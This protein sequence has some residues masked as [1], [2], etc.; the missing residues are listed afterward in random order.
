MLTRS[1]D[2]D[3]AALTTLGKRH[4]IRFHDLITKEAE[5]NKALA[6]LLSMS[7]DMDKSSSI[8]SS[9][10]SA[11]KHNE[12]NT[13]SSS[14]NMLNRLLETLDLDNEDTKNRKQKNNDSPIRPINIFR[15]MLSDNVCANCHQS[16]A[17]NEQIVNAAGHIW[18]TH[19]FVCTQCFQPFENGIY[20]E[21]E[22]RKYC[23][24]DFQM[25]F[26]PCC[27]ECKQA[28]V[29]RVIRAIQ[30]CFHPDCFRCQLCQI[31]LIEM[32]FS[33][34]N[35]RAL[36]RECHIKEK[37]KD[38]SLSQHI[39][40]KCHQIIDNHCLK[41][42]DEYHHAYHFQCTSCQIQL[43]E[44][45][46]EVRGLLYCLPCYNKL[47]VPVCGACRRLIDDRV[48]SA[49]GK[50]WHVEHFCC[51]RCGQPFYGSKHFENKGLAYCESDYHFLFG[52]LCFVCNTLITEGAYTAC[53]KK[54]CADHF[55][56]SLCEKKMN[57]KS[58]FFD[59]D[60]TPVCKQCYGKI[61]S[62]TRKSLQQ[63]PQKKKQLTL[64][65]KQSTV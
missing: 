41:Y 48:I 57:E 39:C 25:L 12:T 49:L 7:N 65:L 46:R 4:E 45:G 63:Q 28:I 11:T 54:Y 34:Y 53:N 44:N 58:K 35:G 29:G 56:C 2:I 17:T 3:T 47:D 22:D 5:L 23:E 60:A 27:A 18:H 9:P 55:A 26:A 32:G 36:C 38:L 13:I 33:K 62:N 21:H 43:D 52:S 20:F 40:S 8:Y 6:E 50:Q 1:T 10:R 30:K 31:P 14:I 15:L 37:A 51:A 16:F 19:C 24:R 59:V 42:K 61:P 64:I